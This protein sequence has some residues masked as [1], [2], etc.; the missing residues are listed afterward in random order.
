[1]VVKNERERER[2]NETR[3]KTKKVVF[4]FVSVEFFFIF[5]FSVSSSTRN[6]RIG[7][8][9]FRFLV[10][11]KEAKWFARTVPNEKKKNE[12]NEKLIFFLFLKRSRWKEN[13]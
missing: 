11:G 7:A 2:K 10:S 6:R 13:E 5:I 3:R 12:I 8:L 9:K 4:L 1:M